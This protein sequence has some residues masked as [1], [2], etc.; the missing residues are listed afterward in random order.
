MFWRRRRR[1]RKDRA[2]LSSDIIYHG[3]MSGPKTGGPVELQDDRKHELYAD[4][5]PR[6]YELQ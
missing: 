6:I 4:T 1:S 5:R 2:R 3:N